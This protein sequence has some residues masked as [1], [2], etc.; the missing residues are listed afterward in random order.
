[1]EKG[2]KYSMNEDAKTIFCRRLKES[3][4]SK[5]LTQEKLGVAIG[6]DEAVANTRISRYEKGVHAVE[7]NTGARIAD[8]LDTTLAYYYASTDDMAKLVNIYHH[9]SPQHQADL[10]Q[11]AEQLQV[12]P[13][14]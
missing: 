12:K 6:L 2:A 3:R 9:L 10:L 1:M 14:A 5:G 4:K 7:P 11:F 8:A 13:E